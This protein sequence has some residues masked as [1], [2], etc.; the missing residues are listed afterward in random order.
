MQETHAAFGGEV[1]FFL[2]FRLRELVGLACRSP[3]RRTKAGL[4]KWYNS[5][6]QNHNREFDSLS[7]CKNEKHSCWDVFCFFRRESNRKGVGKT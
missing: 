4:V 1:I 2:I 6:L 5:G 3:L 7:P